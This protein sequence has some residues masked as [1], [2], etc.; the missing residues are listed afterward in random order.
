MRGLNLFDDGDDGTVFRDV[1]MLALLG[2]VTIVVLLLPHLNPPTR[3]T[4]QQQPGNIV[5]ELHWP[6]DM[7]TDVDLWVQA[8][9]DKP[10]GYSNRGG[11]V[12]NLLRD[13]MGH[14]NDAG[15]LNY[16]IAFSRGAP[17]GEYTV[18]LHLYSNTDPRKTVPSQ[19][20]VGIKR[21]EQGPMRVIHREQ[22]ELARSGQEITVV[23]FTLDDKS[24]VLP[25][26]IHDLPRRLRSSHSFPTRGPAGSNG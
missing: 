26:S 14:I 15:K 5:V 8:P 2:F 4:D 3:P 22:V 18:N 11:R 23:R 6:D 1:I 16:E 10:V 21:G 7:N 12:F 25:D 24:E 13:D 17:E 20:V 19:V 9:G